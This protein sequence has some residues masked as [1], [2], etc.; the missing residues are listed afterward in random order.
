[1]TAA[2]TE[3]LAGFT[4]AIPGSGAPAGGAQALGPSKSAPAPRLCA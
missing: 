4:T 1:M 3:A 2:D